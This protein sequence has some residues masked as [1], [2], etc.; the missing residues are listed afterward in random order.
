MPKLCLLFPAGLVMAS[1]TADETSTIRLVYPASR[2]FNNSVLGNGNTS[3]TATPSITT[4]TTTN[5][6]TSISFTNSTMNITTIAPSTTK[7][8]GESYYLNYVLPYMLDSQKTILLEILAPKGSPIITIIFIIIFV[9]I[10]VY[11]WN[12]ALL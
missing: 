7:Q 10:T 9:C 5:T 2:E 3:T 1:V 12:N 4:T 8:K 6:S 11:L